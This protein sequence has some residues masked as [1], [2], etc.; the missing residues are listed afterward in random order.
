ML[1]PVFHPNI[2]PHAICIGDHWSPGEP[3]WSIIARIG[4]MIS[5]QSYNT[6]SPLNGEAA[7]WVEH[8]VEELPLDSVSLMPDDS[9]SEHRDRDTVAAPPR[10]GAVQ[11]APV[12]TAPAPSAVQSE[13]PAAAPAPAVLSGGA[14]FLTCPTCQ[15]TLRLSAE[16]AGKRIRCPR[17]QGILRAPAAPEPPQ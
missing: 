7:R 10:D 12:A 13:T 1:T 15:S 9:R 2:A 8:H 17:C 14:R 16:M 4:E 3:L 11:S 6:R 5:Y